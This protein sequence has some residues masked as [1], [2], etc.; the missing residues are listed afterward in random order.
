VG[1]KGIPENGIAKLF[2][3]GCAPAF[4]IVADEVEI[5]NKDRAK[6]DRLPVIRPMSANDARRVAAEQR[7]ANVALAT[8]L[9]GTTTPTV[10]LGTNGQLVTPIAVLTGVTAPRAETKPEGQPSRKNGK[11]GRKNL[12]PGIKAQHLAATP[13]GTITARVYF[14]EPTEKV[15]PEVQATA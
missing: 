9:L 3:G 7:E 6:K 15:A 10:K 14:D 2:C 11:K 5:K 4:E 1:T 12:Q 13:E 8:S